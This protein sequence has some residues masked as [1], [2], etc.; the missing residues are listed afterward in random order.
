MSTPAP[1][2]TP[3]TGKSHHLR[4]HL[5]GEEVMTG[6]SIVNIQPGPGV[7]YVGSVTDLSAFGDETVSEIYASHVYEHL[8][9]RG[10]IQRAFK[11]AHR[12]L[13]K[14][15]VLRIAV[16]DLVVVC[17]LFA[18]PQTT[19]Q[20]RMELMQVIY[21]GQKDAFD[22]HKVGYSFDLLCSFLREAGFRQGQR[23][24]DFN[25]FDD[26]SRITFAGKPFSLNVN[27]IK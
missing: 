18:H 8:D 24:A 14:Q 4:L 3:G 21:G 15:G 9:Y 11:E 12:V 6:W 2:S 26:T 16:P 23:V 5:G 13:T 20:E 17:A 25:I 27:V 19:T 1:A 7:D 22:Y 10:E